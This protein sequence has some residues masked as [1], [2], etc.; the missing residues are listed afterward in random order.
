MLY[1][2]SVVSVEHCIGRLTLSVENLYCLSASI[3]RSVY[4]RERTAAINF[5]DGLIE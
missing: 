1:N 5:R 2:N 4:C 3:L